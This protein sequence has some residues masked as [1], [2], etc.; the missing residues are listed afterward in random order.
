M[1]ELTRETLP[2]TGPEPLDP[3]VL[4]AI[5]SSASRMAGAEEAF[6][7]LLH[8]EIET[9]VGPL[10]DAGWPMCER[11]ARA[12]L[13]LALSDP[14]A[15]AVTHSLRWLREA[16]QAD[17]FPESEY[18]SIGHALVRIAREMAGTRWTTTTGSAWIRFFMWL[19]PHLQT[20]ARRPAARQPAPHQDEVPREAGRREPAPRETAPQQIREPAPRETAPQQIVVPNYE[21]ARQPVADAAADALGLHGVFSGV[22]EPAPADDQAMLGVIPPQRDE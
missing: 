12:I 18:V 20:D 3:A 19:Q 6:I 15:D 21:A 10:P 4:Q 1:T 11:T 14:P 13:W 22:D 8:E 16:N 5:R 9:L 17:G 2:E 7:R